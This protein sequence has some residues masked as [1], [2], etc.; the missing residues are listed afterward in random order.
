MADTLRRNPFLGRDDLKRHEGMTTTDITTKMNSA[1]MIWNYHGKML[2][3]E[4][5]AGF[6][7]ATQDPKTLAVRPKIG[8][9]VREGTG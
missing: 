3:M 5:L 8:W 6:I 7:G 4:L 2:Q 9:A 1:P